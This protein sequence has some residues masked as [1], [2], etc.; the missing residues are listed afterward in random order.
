ML[1][2]LHL[3]LRYTGI[4][5]RSQMEYRASCIML[6]IANCL[7][8]GIEFIGILALF[9][10]FKHLRGWSLP[11]AAMLYGMI[12]I[13]FAIAEAAFRGFDVFYQM[14]KEGGFDRILLR[15]R[16]TVLQLMGQELQLMRLG[17]FAQGLVVLI[18]SLSA[19]GVKWSIAKTILLIGAVCGGTCLFGGLFVIQ[20]TIAFWTIESLEV[21][22]TVTYGG[23]ETAQFPISIYNP[24]MRRF[25]TF[26]VPLACVN[27][28]PSLAILEKESG[29]A[30]YLLWIAPVVGVIFLAI[31][32]RFWKVGVRYYCSTG[33]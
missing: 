1:N 33:S 5:I 7:G 23:V 24:W 9:D 30:T 20:A 2:A 4:S 21:M 29:A 13:S 27:Y 32:L 8:T 19:L 3:Y 14:V 28:F 22:N 17:R 31:S 15:P 12:S 25:F 6:S 26:V 18:W 10:R 16:S 11:E